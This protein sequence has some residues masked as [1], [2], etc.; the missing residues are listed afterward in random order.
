MSHINFEDF[1][2]AVMQ[3]AEILEEK[4]YLA[5]PSEDEHRL[6]EFTK[7]IGRG[8]VCTVSFQWLEARLLARQEF[9]VSLRR[10]RSSNKH[11]EGYMNLRMDLPNILRGLYGIDPFP[12]GH[13]GYW[14]FHSKEELHQHLGKVQPLIINYGIPW[15]ED[16]ESNLDWVYKR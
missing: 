10:L 7:P 2:N 12:E 1:Y 5:T 11:L 8:I 13:I 16:L 14:R 9:N 15:I 4:G 6:V 3:L